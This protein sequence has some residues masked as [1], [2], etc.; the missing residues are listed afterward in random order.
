ML[1]GGNE[2][3]ILFAFTFAF[4]DS[5]TTTVSVSAS[6]IRNRFYFRWLRIQKFDPVVVFVSLG[7]FVGLAR[8]QLS[9]ALLPGA[10]KGRTLANHLKKGLSNN[11]DLKKFYTEDSLQHYIC[12]KTFYIF[13][14][15]EQLVKINKNHVPLFKI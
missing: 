4:V 9:K 12:S 8:N 5:F 15:F 11:S 13:L 7:I 6:E 14:H 10:I 3:G 1:T 2:R